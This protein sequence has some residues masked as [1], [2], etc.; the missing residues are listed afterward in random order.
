MAASQ[1]QSGD[2]GSGGNIDLSMIGDLIGGL[3]SLN[4]AS[5][6]QH[7]HNQKRSISEDNQESSSGGFDFESMLNVASAFMGQSGNAEG[8]MGLLPVILDT[9]ASGS[10]NKD[11]KHDHSDHSWYMPPILEH[12]HVMW[13]HFR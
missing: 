1:G 9:F 11:G 10:S 12:I 5:S 6:N 3:S 2:K 13:D 7:Q 4:A 8:V